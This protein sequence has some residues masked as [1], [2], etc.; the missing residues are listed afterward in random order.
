DPVVVDP[1][2]TGPQRA[3]AYYIRGF[4]FLSE[5][6]YVSA[7][8]DYRR[9]LELDPDNPTVQTELGRLYSEGLG[10][11]KDL[12]QAFTLLQKAARGGHEA[13]RLYTGYALLTGTGTK[14]DAAKARYSLQGAADAGQVDAWVQ[15]ARSYRA[16]YANPPDVERALELYRHAAEL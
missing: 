8:Q 7:A 1:R 4:T 2:L 6:L 15:L 9:A 11:D 12:A 3:R 10:V 14:A 16:P 5:G 13:A